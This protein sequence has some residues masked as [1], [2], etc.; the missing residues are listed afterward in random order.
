MKKLKKIQ[1][2][3]LR[4][5][6]TVND[7]LKVA[8][9]F[10]EQKRQFSTFNRRHQES[11]LAPQ[12]KIVFNESTKTMIEKHND[13]LLFNR[14]Q[15]K[16]ALPALP[17][18]QSS[19]SSSSSD[20]LNSSLSETELMPFA[21]KRSSNIQTRPTK[22]ITATPTAKVKSNPLLNANLRTVL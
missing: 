22:Q 19:S 20:S 14:R 18:K 16:S 9:T 6:T 3:N 7:R 10:L 4:T 21:F 12:P 5:N 17:L 11:R 13:A 8:E 1:K 2:K 15:S